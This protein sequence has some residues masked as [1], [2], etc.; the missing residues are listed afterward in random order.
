MQGHSLF[1]YASKISQSIKFSCEAKLKKL[2]RIHRPYLPKGLLGHY[3]NTLLLYVL[4][5]RSQ[6]CQ[7]PLHMIQAPFYLLQLVLI[8]PFLLQNC[9]VLFQKPDRAIHLC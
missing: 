9:V 1:K 8:N 5:G 7:L 6:E 4:L 3:P 2:D